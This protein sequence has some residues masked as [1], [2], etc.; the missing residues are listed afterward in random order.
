MRWLASG[1]AVCSAGGLM[2]YAVRGRSSSLLA[3]SVY[4]GSRARR[5]IALT[6]DDGPSEGTRRLLD[7]LNR[8]GTRATFFLCG[9]NVKR[10]PA[11]ARAVAAAGHE[12]GNHTYSHPALYLRSR[13]FISTELAAAQSVIAETTGTTPALFRAPFGVRWFGLGEAQ[14]RLNLL[15]V[16]WTVIGLDWK[17]TAD[18][19]ARRV[20]A[21]AG[22]GGIICL[23]D[24]RGVQANPDV[25]ATLEAVGRL[26]PA[27]QSRGFAFETVSQLLCP[28][29]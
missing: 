28:T 4:H 27:L 29:N 6:F 26:I 1:A 7:I 24:G 21:G 22:N 12:L 3:P 15:G 17:L 9:M 23:H 16:M 18:R 10:L 8:F 5:S 13:R 11:V 2:A 14:R 20:L 25:D 19:I